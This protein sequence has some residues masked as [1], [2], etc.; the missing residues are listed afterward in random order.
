MNVFARI[1]VERKHAPCSGR[2]WVEYSTA[3]AVHRITCTC[4]KFDLA[5][6]HWA[7]ELADV[8]GGFIRCGRC[9]AD[10]F[11][12]VNGQSISA[13]EALARKLAIQRA[14]AACPP[15]SLVAARAGGVGRAIAR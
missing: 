2:G 6:P 14:H 12:V 9:A 11:F 13:E 5:L 10:D 3:D 15:R 7:Q 1:F 4:M 8:R